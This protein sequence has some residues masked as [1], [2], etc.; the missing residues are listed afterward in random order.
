MNTHEDLPGVE[1]GDCGTKLGYNST[2]NGYLK[3]DNVK[4]P[5]SALLAHFISITKEGDIEVNP[6]ADPR[7]LYQIMTSTRLFIMR[8]GGYH[9]LRSCTAAVRYSVCR[10][11][12]AN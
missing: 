9:Y 10:R 11:Q 2:D 1:V 4:V 8:W 3:F 7:Q 5:R 12:F 6:D